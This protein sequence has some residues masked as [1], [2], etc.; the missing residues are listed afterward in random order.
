MRIGR[1]MDKHDTSKVF[2]V[3]LRFYVAHSLPLYVE[4]RAHSAFS[5]SE[6]IKSRTKKTRRN[7]HNIH[8]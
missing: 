5:S 1:P 8:K 7:D 4:V 6:V 3:H 2:I